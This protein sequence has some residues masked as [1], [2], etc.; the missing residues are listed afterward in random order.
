MRISTAPERAGEINARLA[1][2]SRKQEVK[3]R[4]NIAI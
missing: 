3:G 1:S 2:R 4:E